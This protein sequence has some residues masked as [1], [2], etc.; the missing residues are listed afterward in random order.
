MRVS[1]LRRSAS[2]SV[3]L[4]YLLILWEKMEV[5]AE[6]ARE[7]RVRRQRALFVVMLY[8]SSGVTYLFVTMWEKSGSELKRE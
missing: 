1:P 4:P 8:Y 5:W 6:R 3:Q 2:Y 7:E